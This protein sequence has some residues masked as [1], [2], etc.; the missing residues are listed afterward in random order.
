[1]P[2]AE[3]YMSDGMLDAIGPAPSFA[4]IVEHLGR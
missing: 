3:P 2:L 4:E 1:M